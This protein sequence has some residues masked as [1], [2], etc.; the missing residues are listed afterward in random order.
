[1]RKVFE[2][3]GLKTKMIRVVN[4]FN[5]SVEKTDEIRDFT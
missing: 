3:T 4:T 2:E 5:F 1:M